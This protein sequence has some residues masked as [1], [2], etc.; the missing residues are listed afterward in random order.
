MFICFLL[1]LFLNCIIFIP[2]DVKSEQ[3]TIFLQQEELKSYALTEWEQGYINWNKLD[4]LL[5]QLQSEVSEPPK[6]AT[7]GEGLQIIEEDSGVS[8]DRAA[9]TIN[10]LEAFYKGEDSSIQVPKKTVYARVDKEMLKEITRKK[11][12]SYTTFYNS[13]NKERSTNIMLSAKAMHGT[14][15][16]P[17]EVFS[18]NK[19]V[20]ERTEKRGYKK[21]PVIVKGEFAED[22]G[23]GICQV[24]STL[25]NAVDLRGIQMIERFTH[26]RSVPYVPPGRDATVS[27]WGPDFSFK[28]LYNEPIVI[29]ARAAYGSLTVEVFSSETV[30]HFQDK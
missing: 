7:L 1:T 14:V 17:G 16:F 27:W 4:E 30:E 5:E 3:K 10:F 9:F 13:T 28:N 26:S 15:I 21:A 20:G 11:L 24:S 18:F 23:G 19:T 29:T 8:L 22:I 12:G 6:N 25:F 2:T